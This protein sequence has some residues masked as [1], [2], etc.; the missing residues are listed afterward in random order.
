MLI[1]ISDP[2]NTGYSHA[3]FNIG[4]IEVIRRSFPNDL[5]RFFGDQTHINALKEIAI[6]LG[7]HSNMEL[8]P[9]ASVKWTWRPEINAI[10]FFLYLANLM[11][12][13]QGPV[14][15]VVI[16]HGLTSTIPIVQLMQW[17]VRF[18]SCSVRVYI[19]LHGE[20]SELLNAVPKRR[21][22]RRY[23]SARQRLAGAFSPSLKL[24]VLEEPIAAKL[25]T[26]IPSLS[27]SLN[28][29]PHPLPPTT[30]ILNPPHI[31]P[32]VVG[33]PG[34]A[35]AAKGFG[36]FLEMAKTKCHN[37]QFWAIGM[38]HSSTDN[39]CLTPLDRLPSREPLTYDEYV[40]LLLI[41]HYVCLPYTGSYYSF[42][43]SGSLM[44]A[45]ALRRPVVALRSPLID[46]LSMK[47]GPLGFIFE[48]ADQLISF[49][50]SLCCHHAQGGYKSFQQALDRVAMDRTYQELAK[51]FRSFT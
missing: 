3:N 31:P 15:F 7:T 34:L 40:S 37:V 51:R 20:I 47:Y 48:H 4:L 41:C 25:L 9:L 17:I 30:A 12:L 35:T 44:D 29:L 33:F 45:I 22:I 10:R 19:V 26:L 32:I 8:V 23:F 14:R 16:S 11:M 2:C 36:V 5:I 18:V 43:A 49:S 21:W 38:R 6:T 39:L 50:S 42:S 1:M 46:Y 13:A 27:T 24:I 28:V